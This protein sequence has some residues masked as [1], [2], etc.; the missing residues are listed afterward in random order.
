MSSPLFFSVQQRQG[1][2]LWELVYVSTQEM[3][4]KSV[5]HYF[6]TNKDRVFLK[7]IIFIATRDPAQKELV[8]FHAFA[9][10]AALTHGAEFSLSA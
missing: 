2:E 7:I 5:E 8:W 3:E 1:N 9:S 6:E 4:N 10:R